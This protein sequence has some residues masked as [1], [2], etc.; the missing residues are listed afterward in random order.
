MYHEFGT[1]SKNS[2]IS[3]YYS[4]IYRGPNDFQKLGSHSRPAGK[5]TE[6]ANTLKG[7]YYN[8]GL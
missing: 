7:N 3:T 1:A 2:K 5:S 8:K 6:M 4:H